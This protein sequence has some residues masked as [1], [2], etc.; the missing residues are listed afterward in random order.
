M[1]EKERAD[2]RE[3]RRMEDELKELTLQYETE[4]SQHQKTQTVIA[5]T[6]KRVKVNIREIK[7]RTMEKDAL[8]EKLDRKRALFRQHLQRAGVSAQTKM[9]QPGGGVHSKSGSSGASRVGHY[10]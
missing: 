1:D 6:V 4:H 5:E 10:A 8:I 3:S 2:Q 7:Q 9:H